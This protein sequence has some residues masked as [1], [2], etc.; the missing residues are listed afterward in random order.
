MTIDWTKPL[1]TTAGEPATFLRSGYRCRHN[2]HFHNLVL[3]HKNENDLVCIVDDDGSAFNATTIIRN[4]KVRREG[5]INI[6]PDW[7]TSKI[8]QTQE[9]AIQLRTSDCIA[10]VRI[11]WEE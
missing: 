11:E 10:T 4:K 9:N 6:Y 2:G 5:W 1:E 3:V 8:N 7:Y